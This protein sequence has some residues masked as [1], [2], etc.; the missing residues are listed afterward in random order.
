MSRL[1]WNLHPAGLLVC[2]LLSINACGWHRSGPA[3]VARAPHEPIPAA[4]TR[5]ALALVRGDVAL[6][7]LCTRA[8]GLA[9]ARFASLELTHQ[10]VAVAVIDLTD[11]RRPRLG[12][13]RGTIGQDPGEL[14]ALP[15]AMIAQQIR[16]EGRF[17]DHLVMPL[18]QRMLTGG[19]TGAFN[20]AVEMLCQTETGL[21]LIGPALADFQEG[22]LTLN[23]SLQSLGLFGIRLG[24]L[25][26]DG[27]PTG[28]ERQ[29]AATLGAS[30]NL[31][32]AA[33]TARLLFL[34]ESGQVVSRTRAARIAEMAERNPG[35]DPMA[36]CLPESLPEGS[37]IWGMAGWRG[38]ANHVAL[39]LRLPGGRRLA[40]V[41]LTQIE[42]DHPE[43]PR[44]IVEG[45]LGGV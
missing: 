34:I 11:F 19:D 21:T 23:R 1:L 10:S 31:M 12:A 28:R 4:E 7:S 35:R 2:L 40:V 41:A 22:R 44:A 13:H 37:H 17:T 3:P 42:G 20:E 38:N 27:A 5:A 36:E 18:V 15:L 43:I 30:T 9:V 39:V 16:A 26:P 6:D 32:A 29:L 33:D 45:V 24:H 8:A 14:A 25:I